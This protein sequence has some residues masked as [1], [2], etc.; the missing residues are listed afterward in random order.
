MNEKKYILFIFFTKK[1][2]ISALKLSGSDPK[3]QCLKTVSNQDFYQFFIVL[4]ASPY[5]FGIRQVLPINLFFQLV[6]NGHIKRLTD[7]D[8]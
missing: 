6:K 7:Q 2:N 5:R 1:K 3:K 8:I 4:V